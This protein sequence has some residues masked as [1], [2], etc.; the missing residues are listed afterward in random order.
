MAQSQRKQPKNPSKKLQPFYIVLGLVVI[1]GIAAIAWAATGR[2]GGAVTEPVQ[3]DS[4]LLANPQALYQAAVPMTRGRDDAPVKLVVFID[5]MCPACARFALQIEPALDERY[6]N[7]GLMQMVSYDFPLGGA[8]VHSFLAARAARC[9]AEQ[10]AYWQYH[11]RLFATAT[12]WGSAASPPVDQ[13][14]ELGAELGLDAGALEQCIASD[15][16]AD[17][18]TA[19]RLLG[20]QLG[21]NATPTVIVNNRRLPS[22]M[23]FDIGAIEDFIAQVAPGVGEAL[24]EPEASGAGE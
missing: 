2:G 11:D 24:A 9:A 7:T 5:Y 3:V 8:H 12:Q 4:M 15:R 19:N 20:Q 21:V 10:G 16:F 14:V 17:V 13:L 6:V 18:V 1:G 23:I 22:N